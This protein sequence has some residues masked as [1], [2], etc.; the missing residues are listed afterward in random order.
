[1][2]TQ[3]ARRTRTESFTDWF[4]A[5]APHP[6]IRTTARLVGRPRSLAPH[7]GWSFDWNGADRTPLTAFRRGVWTYFKENEIE[8]PIALRWYD[9]LR[10]RTFLG[11]DMSR[12]LFIGGSFEPNEFVFLGAFLRPG[13]VFVDAGANDGLYTLFAAKRVG[14]TGRVVA[15]EPSTREHAR[16][17]E[18]IRLNRLTNVD[19][20]KVA[21]ADEPA[22]SKLAVAQYGHEGLNTLGGTIANPTVATTHLEDVRV[23][24]IDRLADELG[25]ERI[26][27]IKLDVEGSEARAVAGAR[28]V[29]ERFRPILQLELNEEALEAQGSTRE[30]LVAALSSVDYAL[31]VFD[32]TTAQLRPLRRDDEPLNVIAGP[33]GWLPPRVAVD[34]STRS[35]TR[36]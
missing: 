26:D 31:W 10:V 1:M 5:R 21:V 20:V 27:A 9:G 11:N 28:S 16:L 35:A 4:V 15:I 36:P 6:V 13:M 30:E 23:E 18:N 22:T 33:R 7:P 12:C 19:V 25:L 29:I 24:T 8:E 2:S 32:D 17:V 14:A 34:T 3:A